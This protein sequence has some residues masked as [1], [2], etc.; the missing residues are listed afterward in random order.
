MCWENPHPI[1]IG[2]GGSS[3]TNYSGPRQLSILR[4]TMY[5]DPIAVKNHG[6]QN[7]AI[8]TGRFHYADGRPGATGSF[9]E[10]QIR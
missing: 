5:E 4:A 7:Q 3:Q 1:A 2:T 8:I 6:P 10:D 9:S